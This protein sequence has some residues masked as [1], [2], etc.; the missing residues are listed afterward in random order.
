MKR[1]FVGFDSGFKIEL[2][3]LLKGGIGYWLC[4][5]YFNDVLIC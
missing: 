5:Y 2:K 1:K 4:D 3:G